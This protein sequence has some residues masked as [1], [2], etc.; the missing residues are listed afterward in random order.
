[1]KNRNV[2]MFF[3]LSLFMF[4]VQEAIAQIIRGGHVES[5]ITV[6]SPEVAAMKGYVDR[7]VSYF[8]GTVPITVPL[9]EVTADGYTLPITL[10][11]STSGFR[12]SQEATW[13][14]LG[15][16]L[17][18]N[19]CISRS[20]KC[21]D[22][23]LEYNRVRKGFFGIDQ[24]YYGSATKDYSEMTTYG[25]V[26]KCPVHSLPCGDDIYATDLVVDSEP[27]IFSVSLWNYTDK[28]VLND[29]K[30]SSINATFMN[31]PS[32][33]ILRILTRYEQ[34]RYVHFFELV[35]N[36][37]TVYEFNKRELSCTLNDPE[38]RCYTDSHPANIFLQGDADLYASAWFLTKITMPSGK[39]ISFMYEDEV[40]EAPS[41]ETCIKFRPIYDY[42]LY[43]QNSELI[44]P[45]SNTSIPFYEQDAVYSS[46]KTGIKT[47]RLK[48][49][50]WDS[51]AARIS[52][53]TSEREDVYNSSNSISAPQ[54]LDGIQVLDASGSLVHSYQLNYG[55]FDGHTQYANERYLYKRLRL[56]SVKD[57]L[58]PGWECSFEYDESRS[59][60]SKMTHSVDYWGYYNSKDYGVTYYSQAYDSNTKMLYPGAE[61]TSD[62]S[63]SHLGALTAVIHP[64]GGRE[65]FEYELNRFLWPKYVQDG[66][67]HLQTLNIT[68]LNLP[69]YYTNELDEMFTQDTSVKLTLDGALV[70]QSGSMTGWSGILVSITDINTGRT[71]E[72]YYDAVVSSGY[73]NSIVT[74]GTRTLTLPAGSYR[75]KVHL[76]PEGWISSWQI[77]ISE[78]TPVTYRSDMLETGG[79]GL[80][81]R[82]II[83]GGKKRDFTYSIGELLVDPILS[84]T[85]RFT[86]TMFEQDN[87]SHNIIR[88][89]SYTQTCLIQYSESVIP[90]FTMAKG[91]LIGYHDVCEHVA[92]DG[93]DI[94]INYT[95]RLEKEQR[96]SPNPYQSTMPVFSNGLLE[97]RIV[98]DNDSII[99][100]ENYSYQGGESSNIRAYDFTYVFG[101]TSIPNYRF[102]WYL[103]SQISSSVDGVT[104]LTTYS[105]NRNWQ[106]SSKSS[107]LRNGSGAISS[108]VRKNYRYTNECSNPV[109]SQMA[110]ANIMVPVREL[111][112]SEG[113]LSGGSKVSYKKENGRFLPDT[114]FDVRLDAADTEHPDSWRA[115]V[116]YDRYDE[117]GNPVQVTR[118]GITTLYMWGYKSQYPIAEIT[119][120]MSYDQLANYVG[121][122]TLISMRDGISPTNA[123]FD[124]LENLRGI[125]PVFS[126]GSLMTIRHFKP[127]VGV[128]SLVA[129]NGMVT[130]YGYDS[131]GRLT[132]ISRLGGGTEQ[133]VERYSYN[134]TGNGPGH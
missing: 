4:C 17:S 106:L 20:I 68:S 69:G 90:Q 44:L 73:N 123:Q 48:E 50:V 32:G 47:T 42:N 93:H 115:R 100:S 113:R 129:P 10:T 15:W 114:I 74:M 124:M 103:P 96:V 53:I 40:F 1:M 98:K 21:V 30:M 62:F 82:R 120:N 57:L 79:A 83:G 72:E 49:I 84:Q 131:A 6:Q 111:E 41:V 3:I 36:D 80:R 75:I 132:D 133:F 38:Q 125:L 12:P 71:V 31:C 18:L 52:F 104:T 134:L 54:K 16:S 109:C 45:R 25:L 117:A 58:M 61:K 11:Y 118:D 33:S 122:S 127:L 99:S 97:S 94:S 7:P 35:T 27:D 81:I 5:A 91:Y 87:Y 77:K 8:N 70:Y 85:K 37:G 112:Y 43:D 119:G 29:D 105:Y 51:G 78:S 64:T 39:S 102:K 107:M 55:Y 110:A 67:L 108:N 60:P 95:F 66:G 2:I 19:A 101:L 63:S 126:P 130:L 24:G 65:T 46:F 88:S 92:G 22:D 23:F 28:F 14:G 76:P 26:Y 121:G 59:F 128:S 89:Q 34:N 13:V 86:G 9:C 116:L 56:D